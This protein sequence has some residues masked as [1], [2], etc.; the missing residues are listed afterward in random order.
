[1]AK[2]SNSSKKLTLQQ[3]APAGLWLSGLAVL[4][5]I[6]TLIVK[7]LVFIG[8]YAPPDQKIDQ[9]DSL[10]KRGSGSCWSGSLC[11]F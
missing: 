10:D 9:P 8:L 4:V 6:I 1:M 5:A 3:F 11:T 2:K 7:L